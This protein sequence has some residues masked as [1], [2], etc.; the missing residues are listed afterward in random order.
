M[1]DVS[2]ICLGVT[3]TLQD[4][5]SC[6]NRTCKGI[7]LVVDGEDRLLY[8]VTDGDIR[9][10]ILAGLS[11]DTRVDE[12][13][14]QR[15]EHGNREPL[16]APA[17]TPRAKLVE[18]MRAA[19]LCHIPLLDG[20]DRVAGLA[21]LTELIDMQEAPAGAVIMAGGPGRR[22][23][24]LT[25]VTPKP[26]LSVGGRPLM[27]HTIER[28]RDAGIRSVKIATHYMAE[29]IVKHFG[30][31]DTLGV[32]IEYVQEKEPLGTAG[33][34][35]LMLPWESTLLVVNGDIL[36]DLDFRAMTTFHREHKAVMTV[37]VSQYEVRVPFGV[38]DVEGADVRGV[39]EKPALNF[40]VNAGI[41]L[42]EPEAHS[43]IP[44]GRHFNMTELIDL[45]AAEG[46]R[47]VGF[48]ISEYWMDVGC[49]QDFD[50]VKKDFVEGKMKG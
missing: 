25:N 28:L 18:L 47:V 11:L 33:A 4:V 15:P 34:L 1:S 22:L 17:D 10:A 21:R 50:K 29:E 35:G 49:H 48:P 46:R 23:R 31:G 40:F 32:E 43:K 19:G 30:A 6:I 7:A 13:A 20:D 3:R 36:T 12:W 44:K 24:P 42:L 16:S 26:M 37:G 14:A 2:S 27:E 5:M 38:V 39:R 8:T 9:R 45:L 41:Y